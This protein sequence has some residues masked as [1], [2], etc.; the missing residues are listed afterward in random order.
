MSDFPDYYAI[1]GVSRTAATEEIRTAY[2]RESLRTHPDRLA[3]ATAAEKRKA[4][5]R[6]QVIADAYFVL[7]DPERRK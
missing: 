5:E 1:L 3:N 7:S 2:K 4:T 6:F